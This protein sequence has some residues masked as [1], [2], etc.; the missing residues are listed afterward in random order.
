MH[1]SIIEQKRKSLAIPLPNFS[2]RFFISI[3][4]FAFL[5]FLLI[6]VLCAYWYFALRPFLWL[7]S[8]R[9]NAKSFQIRSQET[10]MLA[11]MIAQE[12]DSVTKGTFLFSLEN[13]QVVEKQKKIH[14]SLVKL[15][16]QQKLY[17]KQS[18]QAM[19]DY[20]ADLGVRPQVEID[21]HLQ[22]LQESQ[23]KWEELQKQLDILEDEKASLLY[24]QA[25]FRITA[26]C[27][28]IV[29]RQQ[30]MLGD[31]VQAGDF[32]LS[33][34]DL[35][36]SWID[37][38]IPEKK[39]HQIKIGQ[40]AKICLSA[41]P[42]KEWEGAVSWIGPATVSKV[43]GKMGLPEEEMIPIKISLPEKNFPVKPGL[44]AKIGIK[45]H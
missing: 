28:G 20:L 23:T 25:N 14:I 35:N 30:K 44:S 9:I 27:D 8:G 40:S 32:V 11:Q 26:P 2:W 13:G 39:L 1:E 7:D 37:A 31:F 36:C 42:G 17:K 10:G 21:R 6:S 43:E 38:V 15:Q 33:L 3:K 45:V 34:A 19:Q 4:F 29:L 5:S 12:G 18:D 24:H 16:E 22:V 41:Y